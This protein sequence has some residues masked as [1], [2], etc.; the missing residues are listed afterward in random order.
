GLLIF[1]D[2]AQVVLD[3]GDL[4]FAIRRDDIVDAEVDSSQPSP[5]QGAST[6]VVLK[7]RLSAVVDQI[8]SIPVA[9]MGESVGLRPLAFAL[10]S[11]AHEYGTSGPQVMSR[12]TIERSPHVTPVTTPRQTGSEMDY[13]TDSLNDN[14]IDQR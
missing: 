2:D 1:S 3:V 10:G 7:V 12:I 9:S 14:P 6:S 8:R 13:S 11:Q 4:R 5:D